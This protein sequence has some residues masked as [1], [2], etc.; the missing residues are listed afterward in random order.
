MPKGRSLCYSDIFTV[1]MAQYYQQHIIEFVEDIVFQNNSEYFLSDQQKEFLL[2]VQ[3]NNRVAAKSGKGIGKTGGVSF[4]ILWFLCCF[5]NPKVICTAPTFP[6][7][8]SALW[9]ETSKWLNKSLVKNIFEHTE[10]KLYLKENTKNWFCEPRTAKDQSSA[11]GVHEDHM[12]VIMDEASG[13][14]DDIFEAYD[15]TL[16]GK[17]N[18]LVMIGNPVR[19][20]G[21]FYD[22]FNKYRHKWK[23]LTFNAE[24]SPFVQRDQIEY[25]AEK[26]GKHHDLYLV[27]IK[28]EFPS[29]SP[30][31]FIRLS[32]IQ[33]AVE[34][35]S[36]P[37]GEIE[38]GLDVARFGDDLTV[39]YWRRG[40]KVHPAKILA[41]NTI[42][43][44]VQLVY[45]TVTEI[46]RIYGYDKRIRVKVDDTGVGSGVTD[47]L[48][49]D[50]EHNIEVIP[51]N[52][53]G[54]GNDYYHNE[55][56]IMWGNLKDQIKFISLPDDQHLIEELSTRRWRLSQSGKIMIEPKN[57]FKKEFKTSPDRSDALV[58]CFAQ[59]V[60]EDI[61]V[62]DFDPLDPSVVKD[63][64]AYLGEDKYS[65]VFYSKD[66]TASII[67]SAWDGHRIYVYDEYNGKDSLIFVA[68]NILQHQPLNKIIGNDLMFG[69]KGDDL[70][71]KFRNY[72]VF[73]MQNFFYNE[74]SAIETLSNMMTQ[75][76]IVIGSQCKKLISQLS[77]WK[78]EKNKFDNENNFGLCYALCNL[79]TEMRKKI[80]I[81]NIS[82]Y[83][84][85]YSNQKEQSIKEI[86]NPKPNLDNWMLK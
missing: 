79:M 58:L 64:V 77:T 35:D 78:S 81:N 55:I 56:S 29:G 20:S 65:S 18:K 13:V 2:A 43:E 3:N 8:K 67:Y 86:S 25:Y 39:L 85:P 34:R 10:R 14:K 19:V 17:H 74:L 57:E 31:A 44:A 68:T 37:R 36:F 75:K 11:Q 47:L 70:A 33:D 62:R 83:F 30:D 12:M 26:Y 80:E 71:F 24:L 22:A 45:D 27:N 59:K 72:Q 73:L 4:A 38:I 84:Q 6:T 9:P 52:N 76:R 60:N 66:L 15:T 32:D 53:G 5:P 51:V 42:P 23:T 69:T 1:P 40:Y 41:K 49:L 61:I 28:G 16:T 82:M 54:K 50:R 46:R 63:N 7:L 48:K 21:P